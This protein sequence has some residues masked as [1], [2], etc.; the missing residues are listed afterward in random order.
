[1]RCGRT[2]ARTL[3]HACSSGILAGGFSGLIWPIGPRG[4]NAPIFSQIA[5]AGKRTTA[6]GRA[7]VQ[8]RMVALTNVVSIRMAFIFEMFQCLLI[9]Y[10]LILYSF[11]MDCKKILEKNLRVQFA[12]EK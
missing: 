10:G 6:A 12:S 11:S 5:T 7:T 9:Q 4:I 8:N 3:L 2:S 1:M